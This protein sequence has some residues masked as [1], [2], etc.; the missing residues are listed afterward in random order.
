MIDTDPAQLDISKNYLVTVDHVGK[1]ASE[2]FESSRTKLIAALAIHEKI[3]LCAVLQETFATGLDETTF[4]KVALRHID[5]CQQHN[6]PHI[7]NLSQ[8]SAICQRLGAMRLLV[9][10]SFQHDFQQ[11]ILLNVSSEDLSFA[12]EKETLFEKI[13][14]TTTNKEEEAEDS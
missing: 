9:V 4:E 8:L 14:G 3:F 12:T 7:P 5:Q 13:L 2:M 6:V 10:D 1:A 11:K